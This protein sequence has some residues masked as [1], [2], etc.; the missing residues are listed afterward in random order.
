MISA[1]GTHEGSNGLS[2]Q[3]DLDAWISAARE[4]DRGALAQALM[5]FRDYLLLVANEQMDQSL[6][7]KEGASDLV[8]ETFLQAQRRISSYRGRSPSEWRSWL[9][10]ILIRHMA[11]K[12]RHFEAI[13]KRKAHREIS[14]EEWAR[15]G[16]AADEETPSRE[17]ARREDEAAL[18][19][20]VSRLPEH[21]QEVIDWHQRNRL[22]FAEIGLRRGISAEAAR[23]IWMR[24]L[25]RLRKELGAF[26][27]HGRP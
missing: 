6:Q 2:A 14:V 19:E 4:G 25:D 27:D 1:G 23:K 22:T 24:A 17:L 26:H 21:Y 9:R 3:V 12:R 18:V 7:A 8:Q 15:L 20:A 11:N 16:V 5:S 13:A 10:S